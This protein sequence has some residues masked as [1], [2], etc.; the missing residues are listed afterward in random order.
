MVE[1]IEEIEV[2]AQAAVEAADSAAELEEVRVRYLGRKAELTG[3]LRGIADLPPEQRGPVGSTGNKVRKG[4]EGLIE[5]KVKA[6]R[7][8]ELEQSLAGDR[9]DVTLPGSP[10]RAVGHLHPITR[11]RRLI[12]DV[13]IGLGYQ[14]MEGPEVEHDYYNFTALNHPEGHPAR[15]L[16]DTFYVDTD[17]HVEQVLLRTHTS[18]MQVRAMESAPPPLFMIVPGKTYR[19]D[20]DAT[21]SPMFHQVE[22][23]AVGEGITLADLKGTLLAMLREIFGPD[24]E[25]RMRPHFFPFTEPSVEFDVSCFRCGGSGSLEDGSRCGLCKGIGWIELGGA[26]MVD[27]NV[28]GFVAD[29]GYDPDS[30]TGFAFGF[31]IE[32]IA[33]LQHNVG[34]LRLFFDNDLRM[35]EQFS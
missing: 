25:I 10:A 6:L 24:R 11:T 23:L 20:S 18:P 21:H 34:D 31:G 8:A 30:V 28:F 7:N 32:R 35:L 3:M 16:Q 15:M 14:V 27:P 12:E 33:M 5:A 29:S 19:R 17:E 9:I 4:L 22:G 26:G 13:M 2:E 1:R